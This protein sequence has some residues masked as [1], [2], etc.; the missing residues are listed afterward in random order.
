MNTT[1]SNLNPEVTSADIEL[2]Q[3][4]RDYLAIRGLNDGEIARTL[5]RHRAASIAA[6]LR[7]PNA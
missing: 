3:V 4:L 6:Y 1:K 5:A 7:N 2:A